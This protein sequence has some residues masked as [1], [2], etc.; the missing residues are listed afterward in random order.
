MP[1]LIWLVCAVSYAAGGS[2][3]VEAPSVHDWEID[4]ADLELGRLIGK[5]G[6][7]EV[8]FVPCC[9][10]SCGSDGVWWRAV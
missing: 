6:Y 5:G 2:V 4:Y 9:A 1:S 10:V 3:S 8:C 7:G